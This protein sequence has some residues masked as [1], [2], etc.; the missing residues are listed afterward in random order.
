LESEVSSARHFFDE[1][2]RGQIDRHTIKSK[3]LEEDG[4]HV[5]RGVFFFHRVQEA[6]AEGHV[7]C[8]QALERSKEP[9]EQLP[10]V[11]VM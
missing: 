2:F 4:G 11:E 9:V 7:N 8:N 5:V 3:K 1:I 6:V 10:I